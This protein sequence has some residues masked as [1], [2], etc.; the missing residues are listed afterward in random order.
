MTRSSSSAP[1]VGP[2]AQPLRATRRGERR[3]RLLDSVA[4][5]R[6]EIGRHCTSNC[7]G[8]R[9]TSASNRQ[10]GGRFKLARFVQGN[11]WGVRVR[12]WGGDGL[13]H[14]IPLH[15]SPC[16][17]AVSRLLA[18][19]GEPQAPG[20]IGQ[21]D[22]H[23]KGFLPAPGRIAGSAAC[24]DCQPHPPGVHSSALLQ[25]SRRPPPRYSKVEYMGLCAQREAE[26]SY[27]RLM[28]RLEK[29]PMQAMCSDFHCIKISTKLD[30][31]T[32]CLVD[33]VRNQLIL[34][35]FVYGIPRY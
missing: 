21:R 4:R 5:P 6:M 9:A 15:W 35:F 22:P 30:V 17:Q 23:Q 25:N 10:T 3:R 1:R 28:I 24:C 13:P 11:V 32:L 14:G 18:S 12:I 7:M 34:Y 16:M 26:A 19:V 2:F 20:P 8:R 31:L 29:G 27:E 33:Y